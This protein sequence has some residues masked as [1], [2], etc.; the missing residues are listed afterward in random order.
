MTNTDEALAVVQAVDHPGLGLHLDSGIMSLNGESVESAV[1]SAGQHLCHF[2]VSHPQLAP[3]SDGGP[4]DHAAVSRA[5][6]ANNYRG[7]VSVEMRS[8]DEP[9][10]N[11]IHLE[12]ACDVL[13]RHY[14]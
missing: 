3:V 2:H 5:L 10:K 7:M 12:T 14:R 9:S 4:V 1:G 13:E 8:A 11:L 6:R